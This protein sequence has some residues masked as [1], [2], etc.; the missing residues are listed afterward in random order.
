MLTIYVLV[1]TQGDSTSVIALDREELLL[2]LLCGSV[3]QKVYPKKK[4][5]MSSGLRGN[6]FNGPAVAKSPWAA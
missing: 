4:K 1:Y 5:S 3:V 6:V 2:P